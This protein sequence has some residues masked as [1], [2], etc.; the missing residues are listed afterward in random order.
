M[1]RKKEIFKNRFQDQNA[2]KI[3][4]NR[5]QD[6]ECRR[7]GEREKGDKDARLTERMH[8]FSR[9]QDWMVKKGW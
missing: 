5:L 4:K 2:E 1:Q 8:D 9:M 7:T 3:F 6:L